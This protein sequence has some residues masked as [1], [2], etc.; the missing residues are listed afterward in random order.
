M[1]PGKTY[2]VH[3]GD[4]HTFVGRCAGMISPVVYLMESVSKVDNTNAGD[5]WQELCLEGSQQRRRAAY[6]H[7]KTRMVV[8][9]TIAAFEWQGKTPQELGL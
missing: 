8:P 5:C 4:W 9:L 2:L 1:E 6:I 7:Y 3:C